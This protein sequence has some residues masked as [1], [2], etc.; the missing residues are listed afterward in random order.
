[1]S[2]MAP[3]AAAVTQIDDTV[4]LALNRVMGQH[5]AWDLL[6]KRLL[7]FDQLK[8]G[9]PIYGMV[10][11]WFRA[12]PG[13]ADRR[14]ILANTLCAAFAGLVLARVLALCL[15][16]R[17]RPFVRPELHWQL[18]AGFEPQMRTWSAFPSD[19]AV[20]AFALVA[21]I[22]LVSRRWG[23]LALAHALLV[24]CLPRVYVG[25]H[26]PSDIL[27]GALIGIG[28][29]VVLQRL[30]RNPAGLLLQA[31]ARRPALFYGVGVVLVYQVI[32]MFY[33]L[34]EGA[35]PFFRFLHTV[36]S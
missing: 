27:V 30:T 7:D 14:R 12:G 29:T 1:M 6:L 11:L 22:W 34:R 5:P 10:A 28:L 8:F 24:I 35:V 9:L 17:D 31:E 19:H 20:L 23:W 18:P 4:L 26:H 36:A 33:A 32:T 16:F 2:F 15:P 21:G 3:L 13:Q 25:L